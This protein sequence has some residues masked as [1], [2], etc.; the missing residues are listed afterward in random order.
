[1]ALEA[2]QPDCILIE[3]PP[4]ADNIIHHVANQELEPPVA[5]LVYN[6]KELSQAVYYPFASFSPEWQ[7]MC[8][9]IDY[10]IP[11]SF[12]DLP[13]T[14]QFGQTDSP[15][16]TFSAKENKSN[17][18][19]KD[20]LGYAA[21]LAGY[22]DVERWWE[23]SFE[24][25]GHEAAVFDLVLDL[26][27]ALRANTDENSQKSNLLREAYM[28]KVIRK[29]IK[30]G[31]KNIAVV[32][33]AWH[34]PALVDLKRYKVSADNQV[35][36]GIKKTKTKA[37]WIPWTY[38]RLSR[39]T[40]YG[41]GVISPA[42]YELLFAERQDTVSIWMVRAARLL[43]EEGLSA[44]SAHV[45]EA[46][47]LAKTL[48]SLREM[49]MPG[50]DELYEAAAT[51]ICD[52]DEKKMELVKTQLLIGNKAGNVP[53]EIPVVPIQDDL[54]KQIKT[55][56]LT[57]YWQ[58]PNPAWLKPSDQY[59]K[60]RID[61]REDSDRLKSQLLHRLNIL[62]IK[63]GTQHVIK[64]S[65][66]KGHGEQ[67]ECWQLEWKP[68]LLIAIIEAG[69]W[70]N[71]IQN[72]TQS[73]V[74]AK[75]NE[76]ES[77]ADLTKLLKEVIFAGLPETA[78]YLIEHLQGLMAQSKDIVQLMDAL[79]ELVKLFR[80]GSTRGTDLSVLEQQIEE[81]VPRICIGLANACSAL[82]EEASK[83]ML[84]RVLT[85][86]YYISVL[87]SEAQQKM[88]LQAIHQILTAPSINLLIQGAAVRI[89]FDK[90]YWG[91]ELTSKRMSSAL[92]VGNTPNDAALWTQGFLSESGLLLLHN[93][94]LWNILDEWVSQI[95][96]DQ[97]KPLLPILRRTFSNFS[98]P[99]RQKLLKLAQQGPV[100]LQKERNK[101]IDFS[102]AEPVKK[103]VM[104]LLG[105][106][107]Q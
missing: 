45:I 15:E 95:P 65:N 92:S 86:N 56:R 12:M 55:A 1:M 66:V 85:T 29:A 93:P 25:K 50:M 42:W 26:M 99:V 39:L 62:K 30:D 98:N 49:L 59:P 87:E 52:G 38:K 41:A 4:D 35:L 94:A 9:G 61:L 18:Y 7:A 81:M 96:L 79:P 88:W 23:V 63:W 31:H 67:H 91:L 76:L 32:C 22:T 28:R 44:S 46:V 34:A 82:N 5:I 20:P 74:Q 33:G 24:Q 13:Q 51:V 54:I 53:E 71:T 107:K 58:K 106:S 80:Y 36:R 6:P 78:K 77:L 57:K 69:M 3:G 10:A 16:F 75:S 68:E 60:G 40:G 21:Q 104:M 102:L 97:L 70:G 64:K 37:T 47:R 101:Q 48:A 2:M 100:S 84:D 103:T 19:I 43:R 14:M 27:K 73:Y 83:E 90:S 17:Q 11:V 89:L 8:Y 72:A 105:L